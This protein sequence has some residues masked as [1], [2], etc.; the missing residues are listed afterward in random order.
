MVLTGVTGPCVC[1]LFHVL[2]QHEYQYGAAPDFAVQ[3]YYRRFS[4]LT[5]G[6]GTLS[7]S[8]SNEFYSFN[9][10]LIHFA[11]INTEIYGDEAF[12]A[13]QADGKTWK[14]DEA[15]RK[16]AGAAQANWLAYDLSRVKRTETPY[17]IVCGHRP[18]FKTPGP[19]STSG[20]KFATEIIPV[21]SKY[22]VDLYLAGHE[23]TYLH[24]EASTFEEY[25]VP[26]ILI[27]GSPGNNEF[28]REEAEL[29]IKDFEWKTL[30]PKYGFG[31]LTA[32]PESLKW[33]WGSAAS[34]GSHNPKPAKWSLEDEL[35]FPRRSSF[36]ASAPEGKPVNTPGE[37]SKVW[38]SSTNGTL[39]TPDSDSIRTL[40]DVGSMRAHSYRGCRSL[41]PLQK[42]EVAAAAET[43][44]KTRCLL[45]RTRVRPSCRARLRRRGPAVCLTSRSDM[46]GLLSCSWCCRGC[47]CRLI[48]RCPSLNNSGSSQPLP[49]PHSVRSI[50][51]SA[52]LAQSMPA[53]RTRGME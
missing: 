2:L 4:G 6:A 38:P 47:T 31:F 19:L 27:S 24:F 13:L 40:L 45:P 28:I 14:A 25:D 42:L 7:G 49:L 53:T 33:Q 52:A 11:F 48:G 29:N 10:G 41:C 32:T 5:L 18:P 35:T 44:R 51:A 46:S 26:P 8:Y 37:I 16:A 21:M 17:V 20:N 22:E 39:P 1:G 12:V 9:A 15:A 3:N 50:D 36:A 34:D 43:A 23:H 30:I